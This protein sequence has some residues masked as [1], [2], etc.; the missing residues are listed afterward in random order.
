MYPFYSVLL[1]S[2][3]KLDR[4]YYDPAQDP[5]GLLRGRTT[6]RISG[7]QCDYLIRKLSYSDTSWSRILYIGP[8]ST[9]FGVVVI[10]NT[11]AGG[12]IVSA[13]QFHYVFFWYANSNTIVPYVKCCLCH[14]FIS[15]VR[16]RQ[17]RVN[18][19]M[20]KDGGPRARPFCCW[21]CRRIRNRCWLESEDKG[22]A[23]L[24]LSHWGGLLIY[25]LTS[26]KYQAPWGDIKPPYLQNDLDPSGESIVPLWSIVPFRCTFLRLS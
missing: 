14:Y 13:I 20:C 22:T 11:N 5:R 21:H 23:I 18:F 25:S 7:P 8:H 3:L 19:H 16:P 10:G 6:V 17:S 24:H 15:L 26:F 12:Y 2:F 4:T 9:C 1:S